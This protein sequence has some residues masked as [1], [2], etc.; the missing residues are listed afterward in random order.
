MEL[1]LESGDDNYLFEVKH[2]LESK[3]I[4]VFIS[5]EETFRVAP[6]N[7]GLKKGLWV[8]VNSQLDDARLL[9]ENPDHKVSSPIDI[10]EFQTI[11]SEAQHLTTSYEKITKIILIVLVVVFI[12]WWISKFPF[13]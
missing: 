3:G 10:S 11:A 12:F 4:P 5:G 8:M 2:R 7:T 13:T 1:L 6:G 9:L